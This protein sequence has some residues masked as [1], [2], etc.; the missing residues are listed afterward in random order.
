MYFLPFRDIWSRIVKFQGFTD[1]QY[2]YFICRH[3]A[4]ENEGDSAV[5]I[6]KWWEG[7]IT[8]RLFSPQGTVY[9]H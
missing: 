5:M 6:I 3:F 8:P 1:V 2:R 9:P 7:H 4:S